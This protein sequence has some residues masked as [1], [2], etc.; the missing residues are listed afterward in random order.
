MLPRRSLLA[1]AGLGAAAI[2][3][4]TAVTARP[5]TAIKR[6]RHRN[7]P[8]RKHRHEKRRDREGSRQ[9]DSARMV[10]M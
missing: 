6:K 8:K 9:S 1:H 2:I 5:T 4:T 3:I 10:P 7:D